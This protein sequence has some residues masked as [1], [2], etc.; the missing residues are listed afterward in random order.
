MPCVPGLHFYTLSCQY[1]LLCLCF[2]MSQISQKKLKKYE[3]EYHTIREQ[4]EQQE[5]P[6]ERYEVHLFRVCLTVWPHDASLSDLHI[7]I[8]DCAHEYLH[9][10]LGCACVC[11]YACNLAVR[12]RFIP[13]SE[14]VFSS[15]LS[16]NSFSFISILYLV[17]LAY[18]LYAYN[19]QRCETR[20]PLGS[21]MKKKWPDGFLITAACQSTVSLSPAHE[22]LLWSFRNCQSCLN[23]YTHTHTQ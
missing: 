1:S 14:L 6:I 5:A 18:V 7:C 20:L 22:E 2:W 11:P 13:Q 15:A 19:E 4:Q 12:F 9:G 10:S 17:P 3:K 21:E 23:V 8:H 16:S